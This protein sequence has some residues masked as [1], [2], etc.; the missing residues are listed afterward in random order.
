[1]CLDP[2]V[3]C[4]LR[5]EQL[6]LIDPELLATQ[7][8]HIPLAVI[9]AMAYPCRALISHRL[10]A[11]G[12]SDDNLFF[13]ARA[14]CIRLEASGKVLDPWNLDP[15]R[16]E[17]DKHQKLAANMQELQLLAEAAEQ[18]DV[19]CVQVW[20][21]SGKKLAKELSAR[22]QGNSD[23]TLAQYIGNLQP[24]VLYG[25]DGVVWRTDAPPVVMQAKENSSEDPLTAQDWISFTY[26]RE[27]TVPFEDQLLRAAHQL[28]GRVAS[29]LGRGDERPLPGSQRIASIWLSAVPRPRDL[30]GYQHA[31][32]QALRYYISGTKHLAWQVVD[33]IW[34]DWS[35]ASRTVLRSNGDGTYSPADDTTRQQ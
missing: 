12:D 14:A 20:L 21:V 19:L 29:G 4:K 10:P 18:P 24:D 5:L 16:T 3:P 9:E 32:A 25:A 17:I 13:R 15:K 22:L 11:K 34:I 27:N 6:A 30:T 23:C 2:Q 31:A 35:D 28:A 8:P 26:E 33:G 7:I 1:M